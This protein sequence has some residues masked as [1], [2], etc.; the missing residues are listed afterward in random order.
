MKPNSVTVAM[1]RVPGGK[2]SNYLLD[3]FQEGYALPSMSPAGKFT[4]EMNKTTKRLLLMSAVSS[5][6][7]NRVSD[8]T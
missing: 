6:T 3:N 8:E 5:I 2:I 7:I 4:Q 1:K